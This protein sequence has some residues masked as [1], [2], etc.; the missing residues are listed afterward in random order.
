MSNES[1]GKQVYTSAQ[2]SFDNRPKGGKEETPGQKKSENGTAKEDKKLGT[3][4]K[5]GDPNYEALSL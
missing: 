1:A 4:L 2:E 5:P 3:G